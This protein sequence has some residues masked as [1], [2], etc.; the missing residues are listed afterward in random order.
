MKRTSVLGT[1]LAVGVLSMTAAAMQQPPAGQ[2]APRVVE[3][4][5]LKDNL[6]VMKG[7][8]GNSSVLVTPAGVIVVNDVALEMDRSPRRSD[9]FEPGW[10]VFFRVLQQTDTVVWDERRPRGPRERLVREITGR[11]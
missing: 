3:I 5:K 9:D 6:Y 11:H 8:G 2:Q 10:I 1:L 7:G 4:D